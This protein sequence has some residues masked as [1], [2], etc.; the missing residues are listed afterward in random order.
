MIVSSFYKYVEI[1]NPEKFQI[2]QLDFCKKLGVKGKVLVSK[3]GVN[4]SISGTEEQ[5]KEYKKELT[6]N[7]L[8]KD[9]KFKDTISEEHPFRKT[10]VR[11]RKEIVSSGLKIELRNKGKYISP[12][13]LNNLIES[14]E[15]FILL[16]ARNNYESKIGKFRNALTPDIETFKEFRK[17]AKELNNFK[18][19]KIVTYCTGGVRCEKA[20]AFLKE[21][22]FSNVFQ[23][24]GGIIN[25]INQFPDR[26]FQGRCFVFDDRL[27]IPTGKN[28]KDI[29]I[30]ELCHVPSG[31]YINCANKKCDNLFVCC[32]D[33]DL[34]FKHYCSKNC[35]ATAF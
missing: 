35:R 13:E 6:R 18:G 25:Y 23:L 33:C 16:D 24:E 27:S 32:E 15:D 2:E 19:K 3:E 9:L 20:S 21:N 29:T 10:I 26:H 17:A 1:K 30:C 31:R 11:V 28:T 34:K 4:G 8:F 12:E 7:K 14:N 22:G 5:I